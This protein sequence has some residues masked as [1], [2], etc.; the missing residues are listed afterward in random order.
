MD[1]FLLMP[2]TR[3]TRYHLLLERL[4]K[5]CEPGTVT[6][7]SIGVAE[8]YMKEIGNTLQGVQAREEDMRKMFEIVN[9]VD[10]CP[11]S[12][13]S[14]SKRRFVAEFG[15]TDLS[16]NS[17]GYGIIGSAQ[18]SGTIEAV[19]AHNLI[20]TGPG[21]RRMYVLSDCMLVAA[22]R[23]PNRMRV[24]PN[25]KKLELVQKL[26]FAKLLVDNRRSD[27]ED[28][29]DII[30]RIRAPSMTGS[31][32]DDLFNFRMNDPKSRKAVEK[33]AKAAGA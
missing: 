19:N 11:S 30:L 20:N 17:P 14:F 26:D 28:E 24:A 9:S 18:N 25:S 29:V 22:P 5:F 27:E 21:A 31:P 16:G 32:N 2:I 13:L 4:R 12:I 10:N 7:E 15:C 1:D 33:A 8:G 3:I 23:Q 6:E